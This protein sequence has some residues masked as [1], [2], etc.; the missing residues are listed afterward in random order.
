MKKKSASLAERNRKIGERKKKKKKERE[1]NECCCLIDPDHGV[2][3][4]ANVAQFDA[5][6]FSSLLSFLPPQTP[7]SPTAPSRMHYVLRRLCQNAEIGLPERFRLPSALLFSFPLYYYSTLL[8]LY[9]FRGVFF[10][11]E[12]WDF[13]AVARSHRPPP[14]AFAS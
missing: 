12:S 13:A 2:Q 1:K 6:H 4:S 10:A 9:F 5:K 7:S 11:A 14:D 8:F 3:V